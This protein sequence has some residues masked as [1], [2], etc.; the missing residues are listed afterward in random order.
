M[1]DGKSFPEVFMKGESSSLGGSLIQQLTT[2]LNGRLHMENRKGAFA[3][4]RFREMINQAPVV[5]FFEF[6]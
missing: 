6:S 4:L 3:E 1:D 2:Q 5:S